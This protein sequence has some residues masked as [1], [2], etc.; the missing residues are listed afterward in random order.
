[1]ADSRL[2][3]TVDGDTGPEA[4]RRR[5]GRARMGNARPKIWTGNN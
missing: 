5:Q 1:M 2:E 3:A 4:H